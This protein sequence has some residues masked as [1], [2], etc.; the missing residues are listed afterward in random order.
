MGI[1]KLVAAHLSSKRV[2]SDYYISF[3]GTSPHELT[4][5]DVG[6][7]ELQITPDRNDCRRTHRLSV[8][9]QI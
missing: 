8:P 4:Q 6:E 9:F 7:H 5:L 3:L 1:D 2:W